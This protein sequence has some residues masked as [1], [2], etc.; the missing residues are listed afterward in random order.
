[1]EERLFQTKKLEDLKERVIELQI[2]NKEDKKTI[3]NENAS[4]SD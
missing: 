1:M 2:Q 3:R 4:P